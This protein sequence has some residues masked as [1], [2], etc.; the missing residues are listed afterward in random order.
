MHDDN[1]VDN[2]FENRPVLTSSGSVVLNLLFDY[3]AI[4]DTPRRSRQESHQ[5]IPLPESKPTRVALHP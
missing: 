3:S 4:L 5:L 2:E 1:D